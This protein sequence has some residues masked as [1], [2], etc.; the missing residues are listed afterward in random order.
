MEQRNDKAEAPIGFFDSGVGGLSVFRAVVELL[1]SENTVYLADTANC[2]YGPRPPGEVAELSLRCTERLLGEG[3]KLVVVA[4]NTATAGAIDLLRSTWP[5][6]PFV[7]MEPA[8][9]PAALHSR[10]GVVGVLATSG[11]FHGRLYQETCRR[12]AADTNVLMC[13][14]DDFVQLVEAGDF[15]SPA[16]RE[17]VRRR[18]E[19]LLAAGADHLVLGCTHF[20][21]LAPLM[22]DI[23]AGR[24]V[25]VDPAPAVARQTRR[26]LEARGMLNPSRS[27]PSRRFLSTEKG[28]VFDAMVERVCRLL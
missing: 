16:A 2:P 13:V 19:P 17:T 24:A 11:T 1:P 12:F 18:I 20:P 15:D 4:C 9:K 27:Q 22:E 6:I 25:L 5:D 7:G 21:F 14:A 23:A 8:V 10:T 26:L 3:S 28:A